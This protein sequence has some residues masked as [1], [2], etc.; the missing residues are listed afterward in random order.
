MQNMKDLE[1]EALAEMETF[2]VKGVKD[3]TLVVNQFSDTAQEE[4]KAYS[5][6]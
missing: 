2:L 6:N 3:M 4:M 1:S 5:K